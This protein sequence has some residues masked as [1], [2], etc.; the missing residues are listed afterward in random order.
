M[1]RLDR[2]LRLNNIVRVTGEFR[3][4]QTII[5]DGYW[6]EPEPCID[7]GYGTFSESTLL[8]ILKF[9]L[10]FFD[11]YYKLFDNLVNFSLTSE[12]AG[13]ANWSGGHSTCRDVLV[14]SEAVNIDILK[15]ERGSQLHL[16]SF[17]RFKLS[18][19]SHP[20]KEFDLLGSLEIFVDHKLV[21]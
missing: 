4:G 8:K 15:V 5:L 19:L 7:F 14:H 12:F 18:M 3:L 20:D 1:L 2:F 6:F 21:V 17:K 13:K 16:S 10:G 9:L 11:I